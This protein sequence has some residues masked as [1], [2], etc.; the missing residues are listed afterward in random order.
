MSKFVHITFGDSAAGVLKY[1]FSTN[2]N[3]WKGEIINFR[4]DYSIGPINQINTEIGLEKR[5]EW[6]EK[7]FKE[8]WEEEY[9]KNIEK[10]FIQTYAKIKSIEPNSTVVIWYGENTSDQVGLRYLSALLKEN[11]LYEVNVSKSLIEDYNGNKYNPSC[12]AEC[13]PEQIAHVILTIKKID[14]E[15]CSYLM[16]EWEV[17]NAA[18]ENL[19]ILKDN[20][21]IGAEES[22]YDDAIL[23]N[24]TSDF[25]KAAK[26]I[27]DTMGKSDQL[28]GDTYVDYRV[29]QLIK[30]GKIE[31]CGQLKTMRDFEIRVFSR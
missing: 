20:T 25:R 14:K 26:V 4:E 21:I 3:Q 23:S 18:E 29:R 27:G 19:R 17:L 10:E 13:A 5:I 9:L 22:Y 12:L 2:E 31:F 15:R 28:I 16:S 7:M 6:F 8:V 1:F 30:D 24:C 11:E